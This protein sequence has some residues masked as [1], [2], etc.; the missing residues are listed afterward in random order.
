MRKTPQLGKFDR[1]DAEI[2]LTIPAE[3][4]ANRASLRLVD[5]EGEVFQ[6]P[7]AI[8]E[9]ERP[10]RKVLRYSIR[11]DG[12]FHS[13][14]EGARG[15]RN[16]RIDFPVRLWG[17]AV[18]YHPGSG[19][20][21]LFIDAITWR[22][23]TASRPRSAA[24]LSFEIETGNPL[25]ILKPE[26]SGRGKLRFTYSGAEPAD[27]NLELEFRDFGAEPAAV[28]PLRRTHRF[29]PGKTLELP[30]PSP[31]RPGLRY[32]T[33]RAASAEN[34]ADRLELRRSFA[35]ITPTGLAESY[36]H[37]DFRFGVCSHPDWSNDPKRWALEADAMRTVGARYLRLGFGMPSL[38]PKPDTFLP[39]KADAILETYRSRGIEQVGSVGYSARWALADPAAAAEKRYI[40]FAPRPEAWRDFVSRVFRHF[41]GRVRF[42]ETWNEVDMPGFARFDEHTYSELAAI[43]A[44]ELR[45]ID[46]DAEL[47][48]SG[49]AAVATARGNFQERVMKEAAGSFSI[50]CFHGHGPFPWFAEQVDSG[51]LP[52]RRR[53]KLDMPWYAHETAL[54]SAGYG[55]AAQAAALW[56]KLLFSWARGSIG[57]TWYN[58]V[59][60]GKD[61]GNAEHN[62]GL[63]T[64]D[65]HPKA[66]Y[67]A[68]NTLTALF[69][70]PGTRFIRQL[71]TE[72]GIWAFEFQPPGA[73]LLAAWSE[74]FGTH[75]L[76]LH[77]DAANAEL[78]GLMGDTVPATQ[79]AG[80]TVLP[81]TGTPTVLRLAGAK[82][83]EQAAAALE[84]PQHL[85]L[86]PGTSGKLPLTL[87]NPGGQR[88][89]LAVTLKLPDGLEAAPKQ[90]KA[91]LRPGETV[92][93]EL[94]LTAGTGFRSPAENPAIIRFEY[95]LDGLN[96]RRSLP[97]DTPYPIGPE[98]PAESDFLLNRRDQVH[99]R[100]DADPTAVDKLWSSPADLSAAI[101]LAADRTML[102]LRAEVTD[103][104]HNQPHRGARLWQGDSIQFYLELPG[105]QG[106]WELGLARH[107]DDTAET[108]GW[109]APAGF[110]A[111]RAAGAL[112]LTTRRRGTLTQYNAEIPLEALGI[113]AAELE[114]GFR[115][116]LLI[117]DNDLGIRESW[118]RLAP[119][120]GNDIRPH[121][122]PWLMLQPAR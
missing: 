82:Q 52:M 108:F 1:L 44:E 53:L 34:P 50:H 49:F 109:R 67:V 14:A 9:P 32:V 113:N 20:G 94:T 30:L 116:N 48:S 41:K 64:N 83:A 118:M 97:V 65:F 61:P 42:Y 22:N 122:W 71:R 55:E 26:D 5:H 96:M 66:A 33:L 73:L 105:Q 114:R 57:Y 62:Y 3:C 99:S 80:I 13:W 90:F 74:T 31:P 38:M 120:V 106:S 17:F 54:T 93:R 78:V 121:A 72:P 35:L 37:R 92:R 87:R 95:R 27:F 100:F 77:T 6:I 115:F 29:T 86:T 110:D 10:G 36:D 24:Q 91:D 111:R 89:S 58:L 117:N 112:R 76:L 7:A 68:Y 15:I 70:A 84:T 18:G 11:K 21:E 2:H 28:P 63:L 103:D 98:L 56:K 88:A 25:H 45:R 12:K 85:F 75:N 81:V 16:G 107:D 119:G 60:K 46:P 69:G 39:A 59:D 43:A 4:P 102:R 79:A 51:L 8:P 101:S 19:T 104:I 47:M 40:A 23:E